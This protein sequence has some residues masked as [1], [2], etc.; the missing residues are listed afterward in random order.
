MSSS[1]AT[2]S[3]LLHPFH[4]HH[5]PKPKSSPP[6]LR[7]PLRLRS[8]LSDPRLLQLAEKLEDSVSPSLPLLHNLRLSSSDSILS[9]SWPTRRD[10]PFRYTDLSLL[11]S[12][13]I[14][15]S[16]PPPSSPLPDE[17]QLFPNRLY[18][19]DGH[20]IPSLSSLPNLPNGVYV[21]GISGVPD[22]IAGSVLDS[23]S[24]FRDGDLFWDLNGIGAPDVAVV[25]VPEGCR[26]EEPLH[27]KYVFGGGGGGGGGERRLAVSNPRVLV[28][29]ER[30]G[31]IGIVEEF[32]GGGDGFYWANSVA[33]VAIGEGGRVSHSYV[34]RQELGSAHTKWTLVRQGLS[35]T[36]ELVEISTGGKLSRHNLHIQQLG[37]DTVT[38]LSSFHMS[39]SDQLL[40]LHSKLELDHPRGYARQLHKCVVSHSS[41][42]VVFDGNIQVNREFGVP[43]TLSKTNPSYSYFSKRGF[44]PKP[45]ELHGIVGAN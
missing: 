19:L 40:D 9:K 41:G 29:V 17:P 44:P 25:Y 18:I 1:T 22:R 36:Y 23:F 31:E 15:P 26:V 39:R 8:A 4:H 6:R 5:L 2:T 7:I 34:Q 35:S 33:E 32:G 28:V 12:S 43:R 11:K 24:G 20:V 21:G 45:I 16:P 10:D 13:Q 3:H 42:K 38:E 27:L 30:G 37:P 14:E